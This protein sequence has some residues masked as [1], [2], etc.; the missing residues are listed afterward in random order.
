[1][2][3]LHLFRQSALVFTCLILLCLVP[4][5]GFAAKKP[6]KPAAPVA[7]EAPFTLEQPANWQFHQAGECDTLTLFLQ[8]N[9]DPLQQLFFLYV[10]PRKNFLQNKISFSYRSCF[11]HY[12]HNTIFQGL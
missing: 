9:N 10:F 11:I 2:P 3:I 7:P 1:M 5:A 4:A 12:Y 6:A 8:N